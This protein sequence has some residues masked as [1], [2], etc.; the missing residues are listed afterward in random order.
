LS[1]AARRRVDELFAT[2]SPPDALVREVTGIV[3]EAGGI[4]AARQRGEQFMQ[5]AA[6]AIS[7]I[8]ESP[9]RAA[10]GDAIDYV[11]ERRS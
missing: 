2:E 11:M 3:G 6:D 7:I 5:E 4:D 10:L 9:V 8:P 1:P